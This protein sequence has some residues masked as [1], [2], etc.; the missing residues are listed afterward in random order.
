MASLVN[1]FQTFA[2]TRVSVANFYFIVKKQ[3]GAD[4]PWKFV[5]HLIEGGLLSSVFDHF[6][7]FFVCFTESLPY[8]GA[9][10]KYIT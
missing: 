7:L 9:C 3:T 6:S 5:K 2:L 1:Q 10:R 4:L 8:P